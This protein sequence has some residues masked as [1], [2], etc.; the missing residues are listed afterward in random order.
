[1]DGQQAAVPELVSKGQFAVLTNVSKGRVSQWIAEGKIDGDALDGEGRDAK[2]RVPIALAQLKKRLNIDQRFGNGL[3]AR[4]DLRLVSPR[5]TNRAGRSGTAS[6]ATVEEKIALERL[7]QL[8][9]NN[10]QAAKE[11]ATR[12]GLLTD[13]EDARRQFGRIAQSMVT[14]FEGAL[15]DLATSISAQPSSCRSAT[16]C[17]ICA[18]SF[19]RCARRR[20]SVRRA[21]G[22]LLELTEIEIGDR[23]DDDA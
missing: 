3:G 8:Q 19:A 20:P 22:E 9:R 14:V 2:V 7:E 5:T 23:E 18:A 4:L 17:I 12:A 11:E 15:T 16:C 21:S 10:R 13:A 6:A 1:M